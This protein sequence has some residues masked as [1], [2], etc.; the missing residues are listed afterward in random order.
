KKRTAEFVG[1][2]SSVF[3]FA[4]PLGS[5]LAGLVAGLAAIFVGGPQSYRWTFITAGIMLIIGGILLRNVH[6][7]RVVDEE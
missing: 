4:Q 2:G 3:S 1:L 6:P 5:V 7:E